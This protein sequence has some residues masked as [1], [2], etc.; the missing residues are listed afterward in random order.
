MKYILL[1]FTMAASVCAAPVLFAGPDDSPFGGSFMDDL[2]KPYDDTAVELPGS[3]TTARQT[4]GA[5]ATTVLLPRKHLLRSRRNPAARLL[6]LR[7][8]RSPNPPPRPRRGQRVSRPTART[9]PIRNASRRRR[10]IIRNPASTGIRS[11]PI[12]S[13][14]RTTTS[15]K[16][17]T[18]SRTTPV[19]NMMKRAG[20]SRRSWAK[21]CRRSW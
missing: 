15:T 10:G 7:P 17:R 19:R 5:P 2:I 18:T 3:L 16:T 12:S 9:S 4:P 20:R 6:R 8:R 14:S 11:T 21:A 13:R 1:T